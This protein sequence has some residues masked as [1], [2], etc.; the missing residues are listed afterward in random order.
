METKKAFKLFTIF[1]YKEEQDYL[2]KMHQ[3]GWKFIK[4]SK[5]SVYHFEKC[6]PEDVIYQLDYNRD[7][8]KNIDEYV[9]CSTIAVGNICNAIPDIAIFENPQRKQQGQR[10]Y[11][12]ITIH[13]YRCGCVY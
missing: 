8:I 4:V 11:S 10:K 9:R 6:I 1:Q 3:S 5:L 2:R 12:V 7:G 13:D